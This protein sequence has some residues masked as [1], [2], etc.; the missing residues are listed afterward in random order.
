MCDETSETATGNEPSET[1]KGDETSKTAAGDEVT[2][3]T[4]GEKPLMRAV[5]DNSPTEATSGDVPIEDADTSNEPAMEE[6]VTDDEGLVLKGAEAEDE[7]TDMGATR[8][9]RFTRAVA[10]AGQEAECR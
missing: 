9:F 3:A 10:A 6:V 5:A 2:E 1:S 8:G 7:T 4:V